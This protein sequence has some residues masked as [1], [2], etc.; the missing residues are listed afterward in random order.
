MD[1]VHIEDE[2]ERKERSMRATADADRSIATENVAPAAV[3]AADPP[4]T[5]AAAADTPKFKLVATDEKAV[6][7]ASKIHAAVVA[8]TPEV[9]AKYKKAYPGWHIEL[10]STPEE[11]GGVLGT[12]DHSIITKEL[13][14]DS[15]H[16]KKALRQGWIRPFLLL[17]AMHPIIRFRTA[18]HLTVDLLENKGFGDPHREAWN[19]I[20]KG[21]VGLQSS[22]EHFFREKLFTKEVTWLQTIGR[23]AKRMERAQDAEEE[24]EKWENMSEEE[25]K[26]TGEKED[27]K[28]KKDE[29]SEARK[30]KRE[31]DECA[32]KGDF[33]SFN[34]LAPSIEEFLTLGVLLV[35]ES[36]A[37]IRAKEAG[38]ERNKFSSWQDFQDR[39]TDKERKTAAG[40]TFETE[41]LRLIGVNNLARSDE[42]RNKERRQAR[43]DL[44]TVADDSREGKFTNQEKTKVLLPAV[45]LL[46]GG[47]LA[48]ITLPVQAANV[49]FRR[50]PGRAFP[51]VM[52]V[53][54]SRAR[55]EANGI[56]IEDY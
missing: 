50:T 10:N 1:G 31:A 20:R 22:S 35:L 4:A 6:E 26:A 52:E 25:L 28:D 53:C 16:K 11:C 49:R 21:R 5:G 44:Q 40:Y 55:L 3:P 33:T 48:V 27:Q 43:I 46:L 19:I 30:L 9:V 2:K 41:D 15:S 42:L 18:R 36:V 13:E 7:K 32:S 24:D 34:K 23:M 29:L 14:R 54:F 51:S 38:Y 39:A 12:A 17:V 45:M 47:A 37:D 56:H 8:L